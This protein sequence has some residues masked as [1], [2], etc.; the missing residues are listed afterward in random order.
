MAQVDEKQSK[1]ESSD[2]S[3]MKVAELRDLLKGKKLS[4]QG[5]KA[6]LIARLEESEHPKLNDAKSIEEDSKIDDELSKQNVKNLETKE[7]E[8]QNDNTD[9]NFSSLKVAELK[10]KK[11]VNEIEEKKDD[12]VPKQNQNN[13]SDLVVLNSKEK[14]LS[15]SKTLGKYDDNDDGKMDHF[16]FV[17][18]HTD[19]VENKGIAG[20]FDRFLDDNPQMRGQR[21]SLIHI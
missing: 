18:H 7:E 2:F 21:L 8:D 17:D 12:D 13:F 15:V 14:P 3:S 4:T 9:S 1:V 19:E 11:S 5:R 20:I 16:E 10:D 6:E